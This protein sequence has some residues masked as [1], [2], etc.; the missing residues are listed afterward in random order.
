MIKKSFL[1]LGLCLVA[2]VVLA[3]E[4]DYKKFMEGYAKAYSSM[5]S[6]QLEDYVS[7]KLIAKLKWEFHEF[8]KAHQKPQLTLKNIVKKGNTITCNATLIVGGK[9]KYKNKAMSFV[10]QGSEIQSY[11]EDRR[12]AKRKVHGR[13]SARDFW[14]AAKQAEAF[15]LVKIERYKSSKFEKLLPLPK[16]YDNEQVK[17]SKWIQYYIPKSGQYLVPV[18]KNKAVYNIVG[19]G[20]RFPAYN[21]KTVDA[22]LKQWKEFKALDKNKEAGSLKKIIADKSSPEMIQSAIARLAVTGYFK[23]KLSKQD[24]V[25]W[26]KLI[27]DEKQPRELVSHLIYLLSKDNFAVAKPILERALKDEKLTTMA[28]PPLARRGRKTFAKLMLEWLKDDKMRK[29]ALRNSF[30][31]IKNKDFV[32]AAMKYFKNSGVEEVKQYML[33]LLAK[34]NAKGNAVIREILKRQAEEYKKLIPQIYMIIIRTNNPA[35]IN[36]IISLAQQKEEKGFYTRLK[37]MAMAYLCKHKNKKGLE[38]TKKY[39]E[40]IKDDKRKQQACLIAFSMVYRRRARSIKEIK[41][42]VSTNGTK[43]IKR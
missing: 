8:R 25:L 28:A 34:D 26:E 19:Y 29:L 23:T 3:L 16:D 11:K 21:P 13:A 30:M 18:Y 12:V 27:F 31:F 22:F 14:S 7:K 40:F 1:I 5:D 38:L 2:S 42:M 41:D 20:Y 32:E 43:K 33:V 6:K 35:W 4:T 37:P 17:L 15:A 9:T 39:L 36:E 24:I 10:L